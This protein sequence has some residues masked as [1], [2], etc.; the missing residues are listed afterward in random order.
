M[1]NCT[2]LRLWQKILCVGWGVR[3][4]SDV[5]RLGDRGVW[6]EVVEVEAESSRLTSC[7]SSP[8]SSKTTNH[9]V[10]LTART[11]ETRWETR[12]GERESYW[13]ECLTEEITTNIHTRTTGRIIHSH[14][15]NRSV[16]QERKDLTCDECLLVQRLQDSF[17]S[18]NPERGAAC[19][20]WH[21]IHQTEHR[22]ETRS[23][24][25]GRG[26]ECVKYCKEKRTQ[27]YFK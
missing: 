24:Q 10:T 26:T 6:L 18:D 16:L 5:V 19:D 7:C 17:T 1:V 25:E 22:M 23:T 11:G 14:A 21:H 20:R 9:S 13:A 27:K 8:A 15:Q 12:R 4:V 3:L 2:G